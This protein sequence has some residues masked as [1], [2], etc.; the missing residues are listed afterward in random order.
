MISLALQSQLHRTKYL[1]T[2]EATHCS[3]VCELL[4]IVDTDWRECINIEQHMHLMMMKAST[5]KFYS[6]FMWAFNVLAGVLY[7]GTDNFVAFIS[8]TMNHNI[9]SRPFPVTMLLPFEAE[10]S[11]IYELIV[12]VTFL[13]A[14]SIVCLVNFFSGLILT[15]VCFAKFCNKLADN[16]KILNRKNR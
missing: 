11:P 1:Y 16:L 8:M 2:I 7:F 3:I 15:L 6:H 4:T 10:Q 12:I 14:M 5:A 13:H 9:T